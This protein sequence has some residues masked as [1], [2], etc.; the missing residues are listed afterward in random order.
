M[1][2]SEYPKYGYSGENIEDLKIPFACLA[3]DIQAHQ[4]VYINSGNIYDAIR[5]SI[6][7]PSV[8][9]PVIR[10]NMVLVDGGVLNNIPIDYA[11]KLI[12]KIKYLQ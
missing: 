3:T 5:A 9:T 12:R 8:F 11:I 1:K 7:I 2:N 10:D 6:A 4:P